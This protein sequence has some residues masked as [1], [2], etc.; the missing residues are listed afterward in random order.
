MII[1]QRQEKFKK[2]NKFNFKNEAFS[3]TGNVAILKF[4]KSYS[5]FFISLSDILNKFII[6]KSAAMVL[7]KKEPRRKRKAPN[8]MEHLI[9]S[10]DHFFDLYNITDIIIYSFIRPSLFLNFALR[11][12]RVKNINIIKIIIKRNMPF[13]LYRG[14]KAK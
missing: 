7:G 8:T 12:V 1:S 3:K 14:R 6:G 4:N 2:K 5:N 13:S 10:L 9:N 11:Y